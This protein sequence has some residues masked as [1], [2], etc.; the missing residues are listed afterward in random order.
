MTYT[1]EISQS[2]EKDLK[3]M[4]KKADKDFKTA[5]INMFKDEKEKHECDRKK[6]I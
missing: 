3:Q 1:Q 4:R 5:F 2:I 6:K